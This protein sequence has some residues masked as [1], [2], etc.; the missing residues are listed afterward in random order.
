[1]AYPQ[2]DP[3]LNTWD[4]TDTG[5]QLR[6][7]V[8]AADLCCAPSSLLAMRLVDAVDINSDLNLN[9]DTRLGADLIRYSAAR[10]RPMVTPVPTDFHVRQRTEGGNE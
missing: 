4:D 1:M 10:P 5:Y 9:P 7:Q 3:F 6:W 8:S 2:G